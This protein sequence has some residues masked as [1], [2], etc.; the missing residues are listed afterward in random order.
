VLRIHFSPDDLARTHVAAAPDPIWETVLSFQILLN[1][2]GSLIFDRWRRRVRP[3]LP[4]AV[5]RL[6]LP[7]SPPTGDFADFLTPGAGVLGLR[8]GL[9]AIRATPR[10]RLRH[11]LAALDRSGPGRSGL[12]GWTRRLGEADPEALR[13]LAGALREWHRI[14]VAPYWDQVRSHVDADWVAKIHA[15]RRGSIEDV[16]AALPA[17]LRWQSPVL[18]THYPD[19]RDV[20][21]DGRGL[22]LVPS[23][24]CWR[25]PVTLIDPHLPQVLVYPVPHELDWLGG[26]RPAAGASDRALRALLGPTRAATLLAISAG[27]VSTGELARRVGV[28]PSSASE[29]A[30]VLREAGLVASHRVGGR[31]LH[32]LTDPGSTLL[33]SAC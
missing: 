8:A 13:Q 33:D 11:D 32:L 21:L 28:A 4:P 10:E 14:G 12:P 5:E 6:L 16:L 26:D 20:H 2:E 29:H 18:E 24:F 27:P 19:D 3:G 23:F 30:A 1:G 31:V 9:E 15:Q 7:L 25:L 17:P 22:L